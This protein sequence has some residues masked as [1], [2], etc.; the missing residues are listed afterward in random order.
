[1][2]INDGQ[3]TNVTLIVSSEKVVL[4]S[5]ESQK[6]KP[7]EGNMF[8]TNPVFIGGAPNIR[9]KTGDRH[10]QGFRGCLNT[11]L[12]TDM[13]GSKNMINFAEDPIRVVG[14]TKSKACMVVPQAMTTVK[15]TTTSTTTTTTTKST[16]TEST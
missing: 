10:E 14:D 15:I 5:R 13:Y 8:P 9:D 12:I 2:G 6:S 11:L 4:K 1:M 7:I 3:P 16:T